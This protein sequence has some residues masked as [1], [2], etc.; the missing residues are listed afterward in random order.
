MIGVQ[1]GTKGYK[2]RFVPLGQ[3]SGKKGTAVYT[4]FRERGVPLYPY[5]CGVACSKICVIFLPI[6]F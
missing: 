4:P 5:R 3:N 2:Y 1:K 6:G